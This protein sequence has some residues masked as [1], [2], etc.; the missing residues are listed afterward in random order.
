SDPVAVAAVAVVAVGD[1]V[2]ASCATGCGATA[3]SPQPQLSPGASS[4]LVSP[5]ATSTNPS[6]TETQV[7]GG[8]PGRSATSNA[9]PRTSTSASAVSTW[10]RRAPAS[11][12]T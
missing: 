2:E 3:T 7:R 9:V 11:F 1:P 4:R 5:L 12:L 8:A 6:L 10:K